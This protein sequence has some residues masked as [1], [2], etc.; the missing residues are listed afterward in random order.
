MNVGMNVG[1]N[2]SETQ[3]QV[4]A[5]LL[6]D[7]TQSAASMANELRVSSRTVE[8]ALARLQEANLIVRSGSKR[9]GEWIVVKAK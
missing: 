2:L 5:L 8:R 4:L 9:D 3:R 7:G 6:E 1:M